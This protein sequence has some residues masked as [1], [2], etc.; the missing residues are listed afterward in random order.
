MVECQADAVTVQESLVR[1]LLR[2]PVVTSHSPVARS[3]HLR[4]GDNT[5]GR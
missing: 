5:P 1:L 2:V 3:A 4:R